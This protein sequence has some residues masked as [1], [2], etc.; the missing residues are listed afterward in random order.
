MFRALIA[1]Q[2]LVSD[3][4]QAYT[5]AGSYSFTVPDNV[6]MIS[7][8]MI[9]GGGG[10]SDNFPDTVEA[11]AGGTLVYATFL[12]TAGETL[13]VVVGAGGTGGVYSTT[14]TSPGGHG[15]STTISRGGT[16][17]FRAPGGKGGANSASQD[18]VYIDG[19]ALS[20]DS[21]AGGV[22]G[23]GTENREGN[24]GGGAGGYSGVGGSGG[25]WQQDEGA[26][27]SGGGG[28]GGVSGS[29]GGFLNT[30]SGQGGY[31]GG[32]ALFG[33]GSNGEGGDSLGE[34]GGVGSSNSSVSGGTTGYGRGAPSRAGARYLNPDQGY[35]GLAGDHGAVRLIWPGQS[36]QYPSTNTV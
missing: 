11:G 5:A 20:S 15:E 32:T 7:A 10:S 27:G 9:G 31:G 4:A 36:R 35:S 2:G 25:D 19:D 29:F 28:G 6:N 14:I 8:V 12:V 1:G 22:G 24:G 16:L 26:D 18:S 13:T 34:A 30:S 23:L 33:A 17:L 3:G 21:N